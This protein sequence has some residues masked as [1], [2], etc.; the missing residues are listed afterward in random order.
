MKITINE[1]TYDVP[2]DPEVIKLSEYIEFYK[3]HGHVLD[4]ALDEIVNDKTSSYED[5]LNKIDAYTDR[6]AIAWISF[7]TGVDLNKIKDT[8]LILPVLNA[9]KSLKVLFRITEDEVQ[10][11]QTYFW[12]DAEWEIQ[13]FRVNPASEMS[14]NEIVTSKEVMRQVYEIADEQKPAGNKWTSMPYLCAVFFRKKGEKFTDELIH[15]GSERMKLINDIPLK[16]ALVV[17]FFLSSCV[18]FWKNHLAFSRSDLEA[19]QSQN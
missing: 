15:E 3:Q 9:Y 1:T 18:H 16:Y 12:N 4:K 8:P 10:F 5:K 7:W 2:F 6:E 14:F 17:A 11:P 19:I 13:D